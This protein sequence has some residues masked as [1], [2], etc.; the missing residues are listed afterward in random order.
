ME[1]QARLKSSCG[2]AESMSIQGQH[3]QKPMHGFFFVFRQRCKIKFGFFREF[4]GIFYWCRSDVGLKISRLRRIINDGKVNGKEK[5]VPGGW[6]SLSRTLF[7]EPFWV[8]GC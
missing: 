2:T 3:W 7:E 4:R 1:Y 8:A 6:L 5:A